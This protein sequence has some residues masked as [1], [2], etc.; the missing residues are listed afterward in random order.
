[1]APWSI[2]P[3][4]LTLINMAFCYFWMSLCIPPKL[5]RC[6]WYA[7]ISALAFLN[8][9]KG[10][11]NTVITSS[12]SAVMRC[13]QT[14]VGMKEFTFSAESEPVACIRQYICLCYRHVTLFC[15]LM[16]VNVRYFLFR[17]YSSGFCTLQLVL[18]EVWPTRCRVRRSFPNSDLLSVLCSRSINHR[19]FRQFSGVLMCCLI[20]SAPL[21]RHLHHLLQQYEPQ[22]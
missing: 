9:S 22:D 17:W 1:M 7:E 3:Q 11:K 5:V 2:R 14:A 19:G 8:L 16:R 20:L 21:W 6:C 13:C 10:E 12:Y 15:A 4:Q 18:M